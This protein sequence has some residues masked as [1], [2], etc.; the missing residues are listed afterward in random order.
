MFLGYYNLAENPFGVTPDPGFLYQGQTHREAWA[1][2]IYGV[3]AKRGFMAQCR[4]AWCLCC[5]LVMCAHRLHSRCTGQT[6]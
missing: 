2:L 3:Q 4:G 5:A 1:S 6:I